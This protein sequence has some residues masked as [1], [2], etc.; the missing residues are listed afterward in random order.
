LTQAHTESFPPSTRRRV[1][2]A[3]VE[4]AAPGLTS[5]TPSSSSPA[6][7]REQWVAEPLRE[8]I[9]RAQSLGEVRRD[10]PASWP[11]EWLIGIVASGL[12]P[13]RRWAWTRPSRASRLSS[14]T[15]PAYKE[16]DRRLVGRST[17]IAR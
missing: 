6:R 8:L 5:E 16:A 11:M 1:S 7:A 14:L 13:A 10:L 2:G 15:A 17:A 3:I 9:E 4:A 12:Q